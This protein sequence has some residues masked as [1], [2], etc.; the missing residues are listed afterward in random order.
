MD[1][2]IKVRDYKRKFNQDNPMAKRYYNLKNKSR[3]EM[4]L[5]IEQFYSWYDNE[6]KKCF[7][8]DIP[9]DLLSI[10][11]GYINRKSNG[12]FTIDRK[13]PSGNYAEGNIALAC[14]LCNLVKSNFFSADTMREL[15]QRYVKPRWQRKAGMEPDALNNK[16]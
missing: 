7:Y 4:E 1:N 11:D 13:N 14:P 2:P 8:C 5:S 9:I 10:P 6:P 16:V 3:G 12:L 15:A